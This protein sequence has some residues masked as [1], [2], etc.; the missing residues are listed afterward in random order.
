MKTPEE[1]SQ[2]KVAKR[3]MIKTTKVKEK[4]INN[5]A[6]ALLYSNGE[7]TPDELFWESINE[8]YKSILEECY[9]ITEEG[10]YNKLEQVTNSIKYC[11]LSYIKLGV[12]LYQAKY[13]KLYKKKHQNFKSY[14]EKELHYRV[15]RANQ[16]IESSKVAIKLIK[17]GYSI[18]PQNE[19][20]ARLL[21]KLNDGELTA[22]WQL[23]L[24]SYDPHKI[25]ANRIEKVVFGEIRRKKGTIKLPIKVIREIENKSL[26]I[27]V[28]S[29]DL[30]TKIMQGE[31]SINSDGSV[32]KPSIETEEII[33]KPNADAIKKWEKDLDQLAFYERNKIDDFAEDLAEEVTNTVTDIRKVIKK[34][35][36]KSF[37][38][39]FRSMDIVK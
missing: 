17:A 15:W 1:Q 8:P 31:L 2:K 19:T 35:F 12:L 33:E 37:L 13:Y 10:K 32:E 6:I 24:D 11:R 23:I 26:E 38:K 28:T 14:C 18:I 5:N 39:P 22:K 25:T 4:Y 30:I 29:A 3:E 16:V 27:G 21:T 7:E 36:I 34:C 20:Q 9:Y